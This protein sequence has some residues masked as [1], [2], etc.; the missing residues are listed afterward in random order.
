MPKNRSTVLISGAKALC[1]GAKTTHRNRTIRWSQDIDIAARDLVFARKLHG[2]V[3]ELLTR[4]V[5]AEAKRK[6]G[7]AHLQQVPQ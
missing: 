1:L 2:G 6:R 3:S 4:L 5:L 7:I